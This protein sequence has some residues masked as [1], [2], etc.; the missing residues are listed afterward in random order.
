[1]DDPRASYVSPLSGRYASQEI[2]YVF[3]DAKKFSTWRR[4]WVDLAKAEKVNKCPKARDF[5]MS[6]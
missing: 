2:K 5:Q 4:L 3:S 6:D 1:M